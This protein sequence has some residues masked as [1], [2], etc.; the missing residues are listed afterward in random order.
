[1]DGAIV[2]GEDAKIAGCFEDWEEGLC[3]QDRLRPALV[4]FSCILLRFRA[5][6]APLVLCLSI[7]E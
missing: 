6:E 7:L 4:Y 5:P 2:R 3:I 1:M